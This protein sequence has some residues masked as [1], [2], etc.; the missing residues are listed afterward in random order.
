[1]KKKNLPEYLIKALNDLERARKE[2]RKLDIGDLSCEV[3]GCINTAMYGG[4]LSS[5]EANQLRKEYE[6]YGY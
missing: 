3:Y 1:M 2:N 6:L 5:S 4:Y